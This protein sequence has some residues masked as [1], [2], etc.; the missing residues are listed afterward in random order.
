[1]H[2]VPDE[3]STTSGAAPGASSATAEAEKAEAKRALEQEETRQLA[4]EKKADA[5]PVAVKGEVVPFGEVLVREGLVARDEIDKAVEL[6]TREAR[7]G[8]FMRL[9][10]LLVARG[11]ID[12]AAVSR[13]PG[14]RG[15][16]ILVCPTCVTQFNVIDY[17]PART[18][19]CSRC[20]EPLRAPAL[21]RR[22]AVEDTLRS[23]SGRLPA[24]AAERQFGPF[25][26]L[27]EISRGGMGIIYKARQRDLD[28]IVAMK[29]MSNS[30]RPEDVTA[31]LKEARAVARLR[32]PYIV[33][34]HG[35]GKQDGVDYFTMDYIEG[36][37]L[38]KAVTSEGLSEREVV[39]L[40]VKV[41][42]AVHYAH[43]QG[44]LHRDLKPANIVVDKKRDPV[45]IDFG[46]ADLDGQPKPQD[47][48]ELVGSPAYLPPEYIQG[49][50]PYGVAGEVYALGA[51]LYTVLAGRPPHTGIDTVQLLRRAQVEE[52]VPIR[53]V[54]SSIDRDV[55]HIVM[56]AL[57][58]DTKARYANVGDLAADLRRWLEGDEVAG[59][60][61]TVQR[62]WQ[63][64]RGRVAAALGLTISL[65]FL[66]ATISYTVQ[67]AALREQDAQR[68]QLDRELQSFHLRLI[69]AKLEVSRLMVEHGN[70][71]Q[72]NALLTD[73]MGQGWTSRFAGRLHAARA[74]ARV[75][76]GDVE[77][78]ESDRRAAGV[79]RDR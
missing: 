31:F 56:T 53:R 60:R 48:D 3:P 30:A 24:L 28:R 22:L 66:Y 23:Q 63:R 18:Y 54:R 64:V 14:A 59:P 73:L 5:R 49:S 13:A 71:K 77:G 47:D 34:I 42:D 21:V 29:I 62:S 43:G 9:G 4:P 25:D 6:Q 35:I 69:D 55:A 78:A 27:G 11:L 68:E 33:A 57:A 7:R 75:K 15:R 37:P 74:E 26:I 19:R 72:A 16:A 51:T 12:E 52:V 44:V 76:L 8:V 45:L 58:R 2:P 20:E 32:H 67:Q 41:C 61:G 10:E 79:I 50:A 17:D 36:L 38:Q 39:E 40:F 65:L 1:V 46:I 70:A